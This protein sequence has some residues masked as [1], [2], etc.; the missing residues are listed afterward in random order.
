MSEHSGIDAW[1]ADKRVVLER[2]EG[3][4]SNERMS[5]VAIWTYDAKAGNYQSFWTDSHGS[6][7]HGTGTYDEASRIWTMRSV[8]RNP[9]KGSKFAEEGTLRFTDPNTM[10]WTRTAKVGG[11]VVMEMKGVSKRKQ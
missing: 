8:T 4:M 5:G 6:Q 11:K 2:F 1:A 10:E 3:T 7:A 9:Q